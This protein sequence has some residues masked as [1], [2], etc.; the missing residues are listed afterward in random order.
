MHD[1]MRPCLVSPESPLACSRLTGFWAKIF[2]VVV[3]L[4]A[5]LESADINFL[6]LM[7]AV[8]ISFPKR[9]QRNRTDDCGVSI[10][11]L[12]LYD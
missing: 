5:E 7:S 9:G 10:N 12:R 3:Y 8:Y 2:L 11:F 6:L 1:I 4:D